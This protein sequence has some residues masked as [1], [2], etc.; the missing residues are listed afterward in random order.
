MA[1]QVITTLVDDIDGTDAAET[2][3][4]GLDGK[5]YE[6]DLSKKNAKAFRKALGQWTARART[7]GRPERSRKRLAAVGDSRNAEIRA[8]AHRNGHDVPARGRIPQRIV[9]AF[10]AAQ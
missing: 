9:T 5:S 6:M 2:I 8:W 1:Q 3:S 10:D 4:F 7:S